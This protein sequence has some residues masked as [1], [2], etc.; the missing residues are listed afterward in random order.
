MRVIKNLS[1]IAFL[2]GFLIFPA[3]TSAEEKTTIYFF[4]EELC[5]HCAKER[6]FLDELILRDQ[7]L[8]VR[9]FEISKN[10]N[11][12]LLL[13]KLGE[14]LSIKITGAPV[15][16]IGSRFFIGYQNDQIHGTLIKNLIEQHRQK[17]CPD[18]TGPIVEDFEQN[19]EAKGAATQI[20]IPEK[21]NVPFLGELEIK[22]FSL[23]LLTIIIGAIDGFNPCAMWVLLFL[24]SLLLGIKNRKRMWVLGFSFLASSA[25]VYFLFLSAWL[26]LFLFL[27]FISWVR[28]SV[29]MVALASGVFY[30]KKYLKNRAGVCQISKGNRQQKVFEKLK[31]IIEEK[32]IW[33]ALVGIVLLA[34]AVNLVELICSAGLP[35]IY[36]QVL[37]LSSL[38]T[39]Q[40]YLYLLLYILVFMLDDMIVFSVAM[41]TLKTMGLTQKY[42]RVSSLIGGILILVIGLLLIFRPEWLMFG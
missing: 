22:N 6:A 29:G 18:I 3:F 7:N 5:P 31:K 40:Y 32:K 26:N 2:A 20:V 15:T 16:F 9:E 27:G 8:E 28:I 13:Q 39:A 21:I 35:A 33:L 19:C 24:I 1:L 36:T 4:T 11:S 10:E 14:E 30:L 42:S 12:L 34:G 25:L 41:T 17:K 37:S 38:N 23:P